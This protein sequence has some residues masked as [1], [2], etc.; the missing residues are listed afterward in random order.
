MRKPR[1]GRRG[2]TLFGAVFR[3]SLLPFRGFRALRGSALRPFLGI[4]GGQFFAQGR[5][6]ALAKGEVGLQQ[7]L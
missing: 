6:G 3:A 2:N 5:V 1:K 4:I 7:F